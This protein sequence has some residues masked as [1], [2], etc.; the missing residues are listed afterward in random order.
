M[1]ADLLEVVIGCVPFTYRSFSAVPTH[2]GAVVVNHAGPFFVLPL[3]E[4]ESPR[5]NANVW[6][7]S[8][9]SSAGSEVQNKC[10]ALVM[11]QFFIVLLAYGPRRSEYQS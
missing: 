1:V 3:T 4:P 7:Q 10:P 9:Q 2:V 11:Y 5:Q 8:R 6:R